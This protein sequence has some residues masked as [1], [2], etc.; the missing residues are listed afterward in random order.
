MKQNGF[1]I[2]R[3]E[4]M[5]KKILFKN[6]N[7]QLLIFLEIKMISTSF[8]EVHIVAISGINTEGF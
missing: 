5:N 8:H 1:L 4:V 2:C 7:P 6:L 3:L